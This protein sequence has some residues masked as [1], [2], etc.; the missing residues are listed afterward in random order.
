MVEFFCIVTELKPI[1]L[2][3]GYRSW[4]T[5][6]PITRV[7]APSIFRAARRMAWR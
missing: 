3:P 1:N 2:L 4:I 5:R 6:K 7:G